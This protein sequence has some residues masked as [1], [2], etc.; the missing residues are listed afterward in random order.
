MKMTRTALIPSDS[1]DSN[2]AAGQHY[3]RAKWY[4][5]FDSTGRNVDNIPGDKTTR[6][7]G[8]LKQLK[9]NL[10]EAIIVNHIGFPAYQSA[11]YKDV[12]VMQMAPFRTAAT[13]AA[14]YFSVKLKPLGKEQIHGYPDFKD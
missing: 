12:A 11:R 8:V 9:D 2:A 5:I 10:P 3:G 7:G 4:L 13:A 14:G 6:C 1:L